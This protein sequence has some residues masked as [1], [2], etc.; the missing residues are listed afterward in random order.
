[1]VVIVKK[2]HIFGK[3]LFKGLYAY[4]HLQEQNHLKN[5][6]IFLTLRRLN[7]KFQNFLYF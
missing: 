3:L 7:F 1:M 5:M 2:I 4:T 6:I